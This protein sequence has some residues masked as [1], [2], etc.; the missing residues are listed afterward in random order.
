ML[1]VRSLEQ[2]FVYHLV[3]FDLNRLLVGIEEPRLS[4]FVQGLERKVA[5]PTATSFYIVNAIFDLFD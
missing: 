5:C 3:W 1:A 4:F 2:T